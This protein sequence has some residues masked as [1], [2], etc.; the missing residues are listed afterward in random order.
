MIDYPWHKYLKDTK[1]TL[2]PNAPSERIPIRGNYNY[3]LYNKDSTVPKKKSPC[4]P[5]FDIL[6]AT[7]RK[8]V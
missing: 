7:V 1:K 6:V 2:D 5:H 4:F 8:L 3:S